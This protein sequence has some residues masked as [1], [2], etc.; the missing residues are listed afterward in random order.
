MILS[1]A[2]ISTAM[3]N[4]ITFYHISD[5][6]SMVMYLHLDIIPFRVNQNLLLKAE[7]FFLARM[8]LI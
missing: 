2:T 8:G 4:D 5:V 3:F 6:L 7:H 1:T